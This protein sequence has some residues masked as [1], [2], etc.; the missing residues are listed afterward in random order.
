MTGINPRMKPK[1]KWTAQEVALV[2][3]LYAS[4]VKPTQIAM[5]LGITRYQIEALL[6]KLGAQRTLRAPSGLEKLPREDQFA[7]LLSLGFTVD[8]IASIMGYKDYQS[9]NAAF[10]RLR[11]HVGPQAV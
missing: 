3:R 6:G 4:G 2:E 5:R 1:H 9:A 11:R 8:R 10:Q 7:E